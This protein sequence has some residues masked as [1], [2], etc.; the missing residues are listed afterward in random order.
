MLRQ[1][2]I[3]L[4]TIILSVGNVYGAAHKESVLVIDVNKLKVLHQNNASQVRY[5]ASLTKMM[6][7]YLIFDQ[8]KSGK[9]TMDSKI[10]VSRRAT[11]EKP[12]KLG[13]KQ[14][15]IITIRQAIEA[16]V[17][18]SANDVAYAVAEKLGNGNVENFV[19]LMNGKAKK[20]GM[21]NTNFVN[22]TGW[23]D[24][25]QYTTAYDMAKLGISL[26]KYHGKYYKLFSTKEMSFRG[27]KIKTTNKVMLKCK[28]VD[29]IKTGF[30]NPAG[31]NLLTSFK[32]KKSNLV[33]VVMGGKS[34]KERDEKMIKLIKQFSSS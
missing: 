11:M 31:F 30:T 10:K 19:K 3:I 34:A 25:N 16:L 6:T 17:V 5:P 14:G 21:K 28:Y 22:P 8:L 32:D 18:K 23:H 24:P 9:I 7:V 2:P 13:L 4:L 15:E 33:A 29:G 12:S 27:K 26:R 1:I 20:L